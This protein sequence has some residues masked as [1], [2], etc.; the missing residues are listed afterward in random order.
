VTLTANRW[1]TTIPIT[2]AGSPGGGPVAVSCGGADS[3]AAALRSGALPGYN[4]RTW[5]TAGIVD[6]DGMLTSLSC[7]TSGFCVAVDDSGNVLVR[8]GTIPSGMWS[9]PTPLDR[10]GSLTSVS[11]TSTTFCVAVSE[12]TPAIA[13]RFDGTRWSS[14]AAPNPSTPNG[15]SEPDTVSAV[16]CATSTYCVALDNFGEFFTWQGHSWSKATAFDDIQDGDDAVSCSRSEACMIVD[17]SGVAVA[18]DHGTLGPQHQVANDTAGLNGVSCPTA[19][20]CVAVGG[21]GRAYSYRA[22]VAS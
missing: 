6:N 16:S 19:S 4:G 8:K 22:E 9:A 20:R 12:D 18:L 21:G 2:G 7:P 3:C 13:Y 5:S 1:G 10:G 14:M 17:D 11:C 15:G